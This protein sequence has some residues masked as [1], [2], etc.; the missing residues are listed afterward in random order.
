[1]LGLAPVSPLRGAEESPERTAN[2]PLLTFQLGGTELRIPRNYFFPAPPP[3]G[4]ED[5]LF[6]MALM[7][8]ME[9]M[10]A[11]NKNAFLHANPPGHGHTVFILVHDATQTTSVE[12][13]L[14]VE[15]KNGAPYS[16]AG[17]RYGLEVRLPVGK[18][19]VDTG[20]W[21]QELFIDTRQGVS[22]AFVSCD[23]EGAVP[24]PICSETYVYRGL[25]ATFNY[26][27]GFLP[28]WQEIERH[29]STLIDGFMKTSH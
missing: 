25:L 7:P 12:F 5:D 26:G 22:R 9:P 3:E 16:A 23:R 17:E 19:I 4:K 24:F 13:R 21:R 2:G 1:M 27:K 8:A 18:G 28:D 20:S 15:E 11:D 14:G 6:I 10:R 29:V